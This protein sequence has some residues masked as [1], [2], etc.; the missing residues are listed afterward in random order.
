MHIHVSQINYY[1]EVDERWTERRP[2]LGKEI[3][4]YL[5]EGVLF[6]RIVQKICLLRLFSRPALPE[7]LICCSLFA[8]GLYPISYG[9]SFSVC[10]N[11]L[12]F[13]RAPKVICSCLTGMSVSQSVCWLALRGARRSRGK[14]ERDKGTRASAPMLGDSRKIKS[15]SNK[16]LISSVSFC[17]FRR[18]VRKKLFVYL[19]SLAM[20]VT[21]LLLLP[22]SL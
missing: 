16:S 15:Q 11:L 17:S 14:N 10:L 2:Q 3:L 18:S 13:L 19:P 12:L 5:G 22:P 4:L 6:V 1:L 8:S 7:R 21:T 9:L 20:T